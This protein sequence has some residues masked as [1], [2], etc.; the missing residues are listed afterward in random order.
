MPR[1]SSIYDLPEDLRDQLNAKLVGNAFSNY[2]ELEDWLNAELEAREFEL[3]VSK[4][5]LHRHGA[6]FGERLERM[7]L[8]TERARA[9]AEGARDD[10]GSLN[11]A[12]IRMVQVENMEFLETLDELAMEP[13][14]RAAVLGKLNT[15]IA[16]VVRASVGS[17][18]WMLEA[19]DKAQQRLA[20]L[21]RE[22]RGDGTPKFDPDTLRRVREEI[23]GIYQ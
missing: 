19:R 23:Y 13:E 5:A 6:R 1:R 8:A 20:A 22:T 17:K 10:E 3:R 21:E 14:Q 18:K 15:S 2:R 11:E 4:S 12:I 7:R 16:R 9:F